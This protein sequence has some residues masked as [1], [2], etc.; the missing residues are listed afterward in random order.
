MRGSKL[1]VSGKQHHQLCDAQYRGRTLLTQEEPLEGKDREDSIRVSTQTVNFAR[2]ATRWMNMWL[3]SA[4][5]LTL[6]EV[7][8]RCIDR[9]HK[10]E[11]RIRWLTT[12]YGPPP[13]LRVKPPNGG[14]P[15]HAVVCS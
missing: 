13:G 4:I 10:A 5:A 3:D 12:K 8:R 2:E 11:A 7:R 1:G 6:R 14:H 9:A 15:G